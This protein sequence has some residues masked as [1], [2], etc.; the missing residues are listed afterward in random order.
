[1]YRHNRRR[2][3][4]EASLAHQG[5]QIPEAHGARHRATDEKG[6]RAAGLKATGSRAQLEQLARQ[7]QFALGPRVALR[8][9]GSSAA[10][11]LLPHAQHTVVA[12]SDQQRSIFRH[13][14]RPHDAG[15][16]VRVNH[17]DLRRTHE[18]VRSV[19][20]LRLY[21]M[22]HSSPTNANTETTDTHRHT[23]TRPSRTPWRTEP[24]GKPHAHSLGS[25]D[26]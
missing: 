2:A 22:H 1:M 7:R 20:S 6:E 5:V 24:S 4:P 13:G 23:R 8:G 14:A 21:V 11:G 17:L 12:T 18:L 19:A 10:E 25:R 16:E 3:Q 15:M 26:A 9:R